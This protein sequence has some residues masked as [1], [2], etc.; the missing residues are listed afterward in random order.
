MPL[1]FV[2]RKWGRSEGGGGWRLAG[3]VGGDPAES[4]GT[5]GPGEVGRWEIVVDKKSRVVSDRATKGKGK[6]K[7]NGHHIC[8]SAR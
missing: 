3:Q 5:Q 1:P 4:L 7:G 8:A 6:G 2:G